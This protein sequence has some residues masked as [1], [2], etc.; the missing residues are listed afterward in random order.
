MTNLLRSRL[1]SVIV[2]RFLRNTKIRKQRETN[3]C[4]GFERAFGAHRFGNENI[5]RVSS[6]TATVYITVGI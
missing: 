5:V 4:S 2:I 3:Y 6:G 1:A